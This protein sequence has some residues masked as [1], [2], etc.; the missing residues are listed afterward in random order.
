MIP[1]KNP[2]LI[3]AVCE[4]RFSQCTLWPD[5]GVNLFSSQISDLFPIKGEKFIKNLRV[6]ASMQKASMEMDQNEL[7]VFWNKEKTMLIQ[8]GVRYLSIHA[9]KPYP[10]WNNFYPII[11]D[12][13][14]K[15]NSIVEITGFERIGF[16]YIDKIEVP[17]NDVILK[18]YFTLYPHLGSGLPQDLAMF[19]MSYDFG[20]ENGRDICRVTLLPTIP[21]KPESSAFLLTTDYFLI[22]PGMVRN[23]G[24]VEWISTAHDHISDLFEG[25][26]TDNL[27]ILFNQ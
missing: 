26:I 13:Y 2:P 16:V 12:I 25:I 20:F 4:F 23:D 27:R 19:Q 1:Y 8:S 21:E 24:A 15:L 3:E 18:D 17:G 7:K 10:S 11:K 5:E 14:F 22:E 9:L 6:T